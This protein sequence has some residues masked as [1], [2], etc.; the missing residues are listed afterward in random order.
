MQK[1]IVT[2]KKWA[3]IKLK[4][5]TSDKN[6][7][8]IRHFYEFK[9]FIDFK[10][11]KTFNEKINWLK[12]NDRNPVYGLLADKYEVRKYIEK[13]IGT[14]NL[15]ELI[16]VYE[17]P[18]EIDFNILPNEFVLKATHGSDMVL[19]CKNKSEFNVN[20]AKQI[21]S[22][23]LKINFY[24]T[25][26]EFV[27]KDIKPRLICE[28]YLANDNEETLTDF[29]FFCFNGEPKFI[30]VYRNRKEIYTVD[31]YD[32]DWNHQ[33]FSLLF[34]KSKDGV[35]KPKPLEEM[36]TIAKKLSKSFK[37]IRVDFYVVNDKIYFGELTFYPCN[38]FGRFY[39]SNMDHELGNL[40]KL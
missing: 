33:M 30:Q 1:W 8:Q 29:K 35:I 18:E 6:Y 5:C 12:L 3:L 38:G 40:L 7:Y 21:M 37:F 25:W 10:N 39:P 15:N 16:G 13:N 23:W 14:S 2:F 20:S 36:I 28:K 22:K 27:Y 11:P 17:S 31:F 19:V 32:L 24:E 4:K 34:P 9:R 26:G